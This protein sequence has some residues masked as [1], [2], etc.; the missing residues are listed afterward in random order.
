LHQILSPIIYPS[1]AML[2][3]PCRSHH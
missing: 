1:P 3:L 2:H